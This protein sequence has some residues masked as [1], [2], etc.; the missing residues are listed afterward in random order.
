MILQSL[1]IKNFCSTF[2][3]INKR[4]LNM[5]IN[6]KPQTRNE[7][8]ILK[9]SNAINKL[10]LLPSESQKGLQKKADENHQLHLICESQNVILSNYSDSYSEKL[11]IEQKIAEVDKEIQKFDTLLADANYILLNTLK[12]EPQKESEVGDFLKIILEKIKNLIMSICKE[13]LNDKSIS[14]SLMSVIEIEQQIQKI[15][16][17]LISNGMYPETQSELY[18]RTSEIDAHNEVLLSFL[19]GFVNEAKRSQ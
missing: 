15:I 7:K 9:S 6:T 5:N 13:S 8:D 14:V 19:S 1:F 18:K 12:K 2:E 3:L 16:E 10:M 11:K 4:S 17:N